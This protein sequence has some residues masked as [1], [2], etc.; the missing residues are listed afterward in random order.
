MILSVMR[1]PPAPNG[2]GGSQRAWFLLRALARLAPV[3]LVLI[4][5][6]LDA[7]LRAVPL[8]AARDVAASIT[9]IDIPEWQPTARRSIGP[10][11]AGWLTALTMRSEEAPRLPEARL[12]DIA[13]RLPTRAPDAVFA[14]RLPCAVVCDAL[15]SRGLLHAPHRFADFDD[16]MSKFRERQLAAL[17]PREGRQRALL[18]RHDVAVIRREERRIAEG[19]DGV[20]VCSDEDVALLRA[21]A[22]RARVL[23]IPNVMERPLLPPR[24]ED[25]RTRLLFVGNLG[26][27]PNIQGLSAFLQEAWPRIRTE[28]PQVDLAVVGMNPPRELPPLAARLGFEL[29]A[30]VP[31]LA[32]FYAGSD[33]TLAP[34]LFGSGTRIKILESMAYG[35]AVVATRMGAEGLGLEPGRHAMIAEDMAGFADGVIALAR[36]PA[37]RDR[38]AEEARRKQQAEYGAAALEGAVAEAMRGRAVVAA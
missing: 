15:Q 1:I 31:D 12:Q 38:M 35:R 18:L 29:H 33:I 36:D 7:E 19:W 23:R 24:D 16:V 3:H 5:R 10:F 2:H 25:G 37:A 30:N 26:F 11:D 34:I 28:V 4:S 9:H 22:P 8:D 14:G 6:R 20:S 21:R 17:G 32:P 13:A 27:G